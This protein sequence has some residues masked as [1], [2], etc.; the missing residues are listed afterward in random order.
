MAQKKAATR[1]ERFLSAFMSAWEI[2]RPISE[3]APSD[4]VIDAYMRV[5]EKYSIEDIER[6]F[7]EV[8]MTMKWFPKP[9]EIVEI[10][11]KRKPGRISVESRA[12]QQWRIV[13]SSLGRGPFADPV[14]A[15]LCKTQFRH[16]YMRD[17]LRVNEYWEEKRFCEA[18]AL[19]VELESEL[20]EIEA[21]ANVLRLVAGIGA[22]PDPVNPPAAA[23]I[24]NAKE[25]LKSVK[26][27]RSIGPIDIK[28]RVAQLQQQGDL[29][30]GN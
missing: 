21:P 9:V 14:T 7:S 15:H 4:I 30:K 22:R 16:S 5:L 17:I 25:Y 19:A 8:L 12:Q 20:K 29:L 6:G 23:Q 13:S 11:E 26:K 3:I 2:L 10:I 28:Q 27:I 18:F 24:K 1:D